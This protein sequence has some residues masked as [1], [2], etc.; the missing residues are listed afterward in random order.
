MYTGYR[1]R[2]ATTKH[3]TFRVDDDLWGEFGV[4]VQAMNTDRTAA[5]TEYLRWVTHQPGAR[6]P[7]R[8]S[9]DRIQAGRE[10]LRS[11]AAGPA[12]DD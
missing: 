4:A 3:R 5:L 9:K 6:S 8:P 1:Q 10:K 7:Q 11:R 2:M 12:R